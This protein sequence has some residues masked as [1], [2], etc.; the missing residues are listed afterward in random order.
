MQGGAQALSRS[1]F[2][3]MV[4]RHRAAEFF[5]FFGASGRLAGVVGPI[6]FGVV[7]QATG[8]GRMATLTLLPL[9]IGGAWV[10]GPAGPFAVHDPATG[11]APVE[12]PA[13]PPE[14]GTRAPEAATSRCATAGC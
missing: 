8:G 1:L 2:A 12:T 6:L 11:D 3:A 5:G 7:T 13:A 9:F 14:D 10:D 4:P